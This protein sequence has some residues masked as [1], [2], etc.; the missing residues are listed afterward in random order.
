[1]ENERTAP[2]EADGKPPTIDSPEKPS[3]VLNSADEVRRFAAEKLCGHLAAGVSLLEQ[4]ETLAATRKGDRVKPVFAAARLMF[5]QAR[6]AE[7][8]ATVSKVERVRRTIIERV[9]PPAPQNADLNSILEAT[10][11]RDLRLKMLCYM[12]LV[13]EERLDPAL[14]EAFEEM[15][16]KAPDVASD[17]AGDKADDEA[18]Y[19]GPPQRRDPPSFKRFTSPTRG[20]RNV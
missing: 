19:N 7:A 8:L 12:K 3:E 13:A 18:G 4:C 20:G 15:K 1:M 17:K 6:I 14:D 16:R 2:V 5:A 10:L 9:Q 11:E